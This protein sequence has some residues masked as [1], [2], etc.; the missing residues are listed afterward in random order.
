[1]KTYK[2]SG[3]LPAVGFAKMLAVTTIGALLIGGVA[4]FIGN[5]F[6]LIILFPLAMGFGASMAVTMGITMGKC[7]NTTAALVVAVLTG[8]LTYGSM[9]FFDY[10]SFKSSVAEYFLEEMPQTEDGEVVTEEM[11]SVMVNAMLAEE[12]G[13]TGFIGFMKF[14]AKQGVSIGKAGRNGANI[15]EVGTWIY[16]L[17]EFGAIIFF[18]CT[19]AA[20]AKSP[21]C[22]SCEEWYDEEALTHLEDGSG[23]DVIEAL[24]N[25]DVA[26]IS[27]KL[28]ITTEAPCIRVKGS[29]CAKCNQSD[30]VLTLEEV[31]LNN[32]GNEQTSEIHSQMIDME[33]FKALLQG[34]EVAKT[35]PAAE[36]EA[37]ADEETVA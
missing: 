29:I 15:G 30:A 8:A 28:Q 35:K 4:H 7:R 21:F 10:L 11:T 17:I 9:H 23:Y 16:Y 22:E 20:A 14:S 2:P 27:S 26:D 34:I 18:A 31:T 24:K 1:M 6:Y 12:T 13:S 19:G 25:E 32:K 5:F 37:I 33:K 3:S 36:V